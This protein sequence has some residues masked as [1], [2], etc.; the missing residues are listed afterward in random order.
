MP[1]KISLSDIEK[2]STDLDKVIQQERETNSFT[3][4]ALKEFVK[5]KLEESFQLLTSERNS[6]TFQCIFDLSLTGVQHIVDQKEEAKSHFKSISNKSN[7][8]EIQYKKWNL[9]LEE[10]KTRISELNI[11]YVF[12]ALRIN[13][14]SG[15]IAASE[16]ILDLPITMIPKSHR[17]KRSKII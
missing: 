3:I 13:Y 5:L 2:L 14:I 4:T 10:S 1:F 8:N 6:N 7:K 12:E 15:F 9:L 16:Y 17:L 11:E